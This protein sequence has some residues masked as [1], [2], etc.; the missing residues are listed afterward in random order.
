MSAMDIL[1][2]WIEILTAGDDRTKSPSPTFIANL[3]IR[4]IRNKGGDTTVAKE[5]ITRDDIADII[6]A[7]CGFTNDSV[8]KSADAILTALS[9]DDIWFGD[10]KNM[11]PK[12]QEFFDLKLA[13]LETQVSRLVLINETMKAEAARAPHSRGL[14]PRVKAIH[15]ARIAE[16]EDNIN[17]KADWIEATM[18]DMA[19]THKQVDKLEDKV[20]KAIEALTAIV[21]DDTWGLEHE[22][23]K[24][25]RKTL[26]QLRETT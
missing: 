25:V 20:V 21:A 19:V 12:D 8:Y 24:L 16:L 5:M 2:G 23:Y 22:V 4:D 14:N 26:T 1:V 15:Q 9:S 17:L 18:N 6:G 13:A 10:P 7:E 11:P 3:I